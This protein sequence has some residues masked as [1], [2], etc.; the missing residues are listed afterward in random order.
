MPLQFIGLHTFLIQNPAVDLRVDNNFHSRWDYYRDGFYGGCGPVS[1]LPVATKSHGVALTMGFGSETICL[2]AGLLAAPSMTG[3]AYGQSGAVDITGN[4][5]GATMAAGVASTVTVDSMSAGA[6]TAV[7]G[8]IIG[9][10]GAGINDL[11][12]TRLPGENWGV[13]HG[14]RSGTYSTVIAAGN[15]SNQIGN[16]AD[17]TSDTDMHVRSVNA[18]SRTFHG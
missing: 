17:F 5:L 1:R 3:T 15:V 18:A 14:E 9:P 16:S 8:D 12:L 6:I 7:S 4:A 11:V 2:S 10:T 13:A